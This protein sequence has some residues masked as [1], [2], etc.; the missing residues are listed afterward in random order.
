MLKDSS[1]VAAQSRTFPMVTFT[2]DSLADPPAFGS[3]F[4]SY[5]NYLDSFLR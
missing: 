5:Y 3:S 1:V 2:C 4:L